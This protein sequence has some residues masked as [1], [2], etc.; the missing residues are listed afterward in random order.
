MKKFVQNSVFFGKVVIAMETGVIPP[1]IHFTKGRADIDAFKKGTIQVVTNPTP[2][3]PTYV[4][5]NSF[6]FGGANGHVLL[7]PNAKEKINGGAP[8]DNL[9][10]LVV[11][12]GRTEEAVESF[13]HE[14]GQ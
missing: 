7:A 4:G 11:L 2:W 8:K 13:L 1:N 3:E 6:G 9:P 12:S 10:R 14:V 5:I